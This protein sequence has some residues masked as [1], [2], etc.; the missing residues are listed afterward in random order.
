MELGLHDPVASENE[1]AATLDYSYGVIVS[2]IRIL[3]VNVI[4][5]TI[6]I[7]HIG[8]VFEHAFRYPLSA[9]PTA[10]DYPYADNANRLERTEKDL[11]KVWAQNYVLYLD[12]KRGGE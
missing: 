3:V 9:H 10:R 11:P 5:Y 12:F 7:T 8:L 1:S 2:Y 4:I 6:R